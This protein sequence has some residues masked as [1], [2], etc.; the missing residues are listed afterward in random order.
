MGLHLVP[1]GQNGSA[2][3][4]QPERFSQNGSARTVQPET[5]DPLF[6]LGKGR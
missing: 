5:I 4:V 6:A 1:I 2:R 3:T